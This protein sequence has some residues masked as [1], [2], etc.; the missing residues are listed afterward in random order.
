MLGM[1]NWS[2]ALWCHRRQPTD[3]AESVAVASRS[4]GIAAVKIRILISPIAVFV[5]LQAPED[6]AT[7]I[8]D[9]SGKV[10]S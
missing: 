3:D 6:D 10:A 2:Q 5:A 4:C 8:H 1:E 7:L 9:V